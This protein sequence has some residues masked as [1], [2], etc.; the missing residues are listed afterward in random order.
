MNNHM[1]YGKLIF[2]KVGKV[3]AGKNYLKTAGEI[4]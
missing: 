3:Y 4:A 1:S 2:S